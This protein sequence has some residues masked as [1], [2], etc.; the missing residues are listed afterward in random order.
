MEKIPGIVIILLGCY[1]LF[2]AL[3][4]NKLKFKGLT[5][6]SFARTYAVPI[7]TIVLGIMRLLEK[8]KF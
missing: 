2:S 5:F 7:I 3:K 6:R 4:R 8:S 1:M